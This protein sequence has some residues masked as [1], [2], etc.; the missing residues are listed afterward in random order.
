MQ[1]K[2]HPTFKR[3]VKLAISLGV[4]CYSY[5]L[6]KMMRLVGKP[7]PGRCVVLYYHAIPFD[8]RKQ[9]ARQMDTLV[10]RAKA[11]PADRM[12]PLSV[13]ERYAAVTFDDAFESVLYN[14]VPELEK[15][16][17][18]ATIFVIAGRMG[19]AP[20]WEGYPE[21]TMTLEQIEQLP[22]DLVT[23]GSHTVTHPVLPALSEQEARTEL[24]ESRAKLE[25]VLHRRINLFSFP[26]G[27]FEK[28]MAEWCREA[29]YERIFTT[30]PHPAFSSPQEFVT[31]RVPVEPDDWPLEFNLK[32]FGA[33]CWLPW[34]FSLKQRLLPN[35]MK[36]AKVGKTAVPG[37]G[38]AQEAVRTRSSGRRM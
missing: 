30:L 34:A 31:G 32:L 5:L 10:R 6:A 13:G 3:L 14:A 2:T 20:G 22:A 12:T 17:I 8:R 33:Y 4:F 36:R 1:N 7:I 15:R 29:G 24:S 18:P 26:F 27:A 35:Q 25:E 38:A 11:I 16:K 9:F 37:P 28:K 21:R 19:Q 23:I